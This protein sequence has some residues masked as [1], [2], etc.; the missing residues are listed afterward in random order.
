LISLANYGV[1]KN[2]TFTI[3]RQQRVEMPI[4]A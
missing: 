3:Y 1:S 4:R 2:A